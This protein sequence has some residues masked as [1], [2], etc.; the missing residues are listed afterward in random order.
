MLATLER[1]DPHSD[2]IDM[3]VEL[4]D[5]LRPRGRRAFAGTPE[6]VR[7]LAQL[8]KG[9]PTQASNLRSYCTRLI[10]SR[11]HASLYTDIGILSN[12]GF[13]TELKRR[14]AYRVLPP[15]LS[16]LYLS[17]AIDQVLYKDTDHLWI[18]AVP[19]A[20]WLTLYDVIAH[21]ARL[22]DAP[23]GE[24]RHAA[25]LGLLDAIRTLSCRVCALGLEPRLI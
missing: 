19:V 1:I 6:R 15:A 16:D 13:V 9:N 11:R 23:P 21:A 25:V 8:L 24:A 22:P 3:L 7:M 4:V 12:D 20:D 10:V 5:H 18:N 14:A 2:R 17:D